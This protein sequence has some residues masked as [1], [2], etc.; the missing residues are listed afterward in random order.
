LWLAVAVVVQVVVAVEPVDIEQ[1]L[2]SLLLLELP[3]LQ[4]LVLAVL[5]VLQH[6]MVIMEL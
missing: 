5:A 1:T 6:L 4:Q 3:I 2:D